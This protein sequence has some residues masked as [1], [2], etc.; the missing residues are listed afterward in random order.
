MPF[1]IQFL[2]R[3]VARTL[4]LGTVSGL[5]TFWDPS[6]ELSRDVFLRQSAKPVGFGHLPNYNK[7][8]YVFTSR[9]MIYTR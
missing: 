9:I 3:S 5:A 6:G 2:I 4:T 1:L 8:E 7:H